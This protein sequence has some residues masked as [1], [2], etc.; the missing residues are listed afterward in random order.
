MSPSRGTMPPC[1]SPL[2]IKAT[3]SSSLRTSGM[4][5]TAR[6]S[7]AL[8]RFIGRSRFYSAKTL[9]QPRQHVLAVEFQEARLVGSRRVEHQVPE[10]ETDI[11]SD[12]LD[13]LVDITGYDP[14]A[15]I[16]LQ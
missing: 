6:I 10:A 2:P 12:P 15:G 14:S 11:V 7:T 4:P 5:G 3:R 13:V 16:A 8:L 1:T 9:A